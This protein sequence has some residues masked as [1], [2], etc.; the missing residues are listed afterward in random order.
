VLSALS[1]GIWAVIVIALYDR[2]LYWPISAGLIAAPAIGVAMGLVSRAFH[3]QNTT[4]RI[5]I[6]AG[7]LY[8]AAAWFG[9]SIDLA[10]IFGNGLPQHI[11]SGLGFQGA[12]WMMVGMTATGYVVLLTPLAYLNHAIIGQC[13][14]NLRRDA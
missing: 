8:A 1:G 2:A 7:T 5:V 3:R 10:A 12:F 11:A 13:W 14:M 4:E 9:L 6:A